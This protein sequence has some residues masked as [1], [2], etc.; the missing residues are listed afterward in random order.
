MKSLYLYTDELDDMVDAADELFEQFEEKRTE[1]NFSDRAVGL[2][3][4]DP[5]IEIKELMEELGKRFDFPILAW[6]ALG[7]MD[8]VHGY[9]QEQIS[10]MLLSDD[11]LECSFAVTDEIQL[12]HE[13][14]SEGGD[15]ALPQD[16]LILE[17]QKAYK[18]AE[19]G[20]G[21][22]PDLVLCYAT[23]LADTPSDIIL[24]AM[25]EVSGGVP[26]FGGVASDMFDFETGYIAM[27]EKARKQGVAVL[28]LKGANISPV[29]RVELSLLNDSFMTAQVTKSKSNIVSEVNGH[30]AL[31]VL[32][33][34]GV[35]KVL[36]PDDDI[37][38]SLF[39]T[40]F[41]FT[42]MTE[43]GHKYS[44]LRNF[45]RFNHQ[46]KSMVFLGE[47]PDGSIMRIGAMDAIQI[48]K[49]VCT[50]VQGVVEKIMSSNPQCSAILVVSCAS[51]YMNLKRGKGEEAE[52][53]NEA[54]PK[55][56]NY[57]GFY[58]YGEFCPVQDDEENFLKN[59]FHNFTF[60]IMAI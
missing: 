40:P 41:H 36:E 25:D 5:E 15:A 13:H 57:M 59:T 9:F 21:S 56:I 38:L 52:A 46:E 16:S 39:T 51:R 26:V 37:Q 1:E 31:Q 19:A 20:L 10:L 7:V 29:Y 4:G 6:S 48:K 17:V 49:H 54:L 14:R 43:D 42:A 27:N 8:N 60:A 58:S 34:K 55:G 35:S 44:F 33:E 23:Y 28:L 30:P 53:A 3:I 12:L 24:R 11:D 32:D 45:M 2:L 18:E 50:A 22:K 47:I